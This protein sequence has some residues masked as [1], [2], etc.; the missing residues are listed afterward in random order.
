MGIPQG[1]ILGTVLFLLYIIDMSRS[2][3]LNF[4]HLADDMTIVATEES[5]GEL[6]TNI[7]REL[8]SINGVCK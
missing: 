1:S 7:N 8:L 4:I 5:E 3:N 2:S 6:F